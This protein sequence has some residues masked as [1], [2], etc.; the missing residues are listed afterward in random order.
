MRRNWSL[1]ALCAAGLCTMTP[2]NVHAQGSSARILMFH[3]VSFTDG[4]TAAN[5][6]VYP[7]NFRDMMEFIE[8]N[9]NVISMDQLMEW[10]SGNGSIPYNA[11]VI[12]FDDNYEGVNDFAFPI[13][14]E[15]DQTGINFAH[16]GFVGVLTSKDHA[17]WDELRR[18]DSSGV[19]KVESHT[20]NHVDLTSTSSPSSEINQSLS[21][22]EAQIS[23]KN[24]KYL[25]YPFG[26]Y[27]SSTISLA[28]NAGYTAAVTTVGGLNYQSTPNFELRRNGVGI[29]IRLNDFKSI[30]GYSGSDS[31]GPVIIDNEDSGFT[32]TGGWFQVGSKSNNYGHYGETYRRAARSSSETGSARFTPN[33]SAG[34]YDVFSWHSSE[35]DP[36]VTSADAFYRVRHSGGTSTY[37]VNQRINKAGWYYLGRYTFNSGTGGYVEISN[38]ASTGT[39]I[40]ADAVKFQ[41]VTSSTPQPVTPLIIDNPDSGYSDSGNWITSS[42]GDPFGSYARVA[43]GGNGSPTATAIWSANIPQEGFYDVGV[44]YT[45]SNSTYRSD[46]APFSVNHA[47]GLETVMVNQQSS[48]N[49]AKRFNSLGTFRFESGQQDIV[50]LSNAIPSS[51]QYVSADSVRIDWVADSDA[52]GGNS[53]VEV[54]VDNSDIGFSASTSWFP[55]TSVSGFLGSNYS[56]RATGSVS[57]A[58]TWNVD[59]PEAGDYEVYARWTT[60]GNRATAAPYIVYH[61]SG[62]SVRTVNQQQNNA[63]WVSLG[64]YNFSSGNAAR[65]RLSCWTSSG[66]FVIADGVKF[67]KQ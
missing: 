40:N 32:Q 59:L 39:Y 44:W 60:G 21:S 66:S 30:M 54:V 57:D 43:Q 22:I 23:G 9:Y 65:V 58:A 46:E 8:R 56:A 67:V 45:V 17:D 14:A 64:T 11:V 47:D 51:S 62:S 37:L 18:Q 2:E 33:L 24:V 28:Q 31:G 35:S 41:P 4:K 6:D 48:A 50:F 19:L 25:A 52:G 29:G 13:M 61:T 15:L 5:D 26:A 36:N 49:G 63:T 1:A 34:L 53:P 10:K 20:V 38:G 42:S 3:D 16:T 12:T 55:S 27:N 7:D